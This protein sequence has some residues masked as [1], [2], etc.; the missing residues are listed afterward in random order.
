MHSRIFIVINSNL[1]INAII[2]VNNKYVLRRNMKL[3]NNVNGQRE[4]NKKSNNNIP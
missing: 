2:I 1:V 4:R 3:F